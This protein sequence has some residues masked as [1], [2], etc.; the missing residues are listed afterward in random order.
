MQ[1]SKENKSSKEINIPKIKRTDAPTETTS[2]NKKR[3]KT[4]KRMYA[5]YNC[6]APFFGLRKEEA[7]KRVKRK[8]NLTKDGKLINCVKYI[9]ELVSFRT[10]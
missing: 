4:Q 10:Y 6:V 3:R 5:S 2:S 7:M 8:F 9:L 1:S